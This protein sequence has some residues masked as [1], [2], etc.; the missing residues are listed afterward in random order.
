MSTDSMSKPMSQPMSEASNK[1]LS[2]EDAEAAYLL[3]EFIAQ[4]AIKSVTKAFATL[5][6]VIVTPGAPLQVPP[7]TAHDY[8]IAGVIGMTQEK[9][10]GTLFLAF[11]KKTVF[12]I[13]G[14]FYKR[15]F[16]KIDPSVHQGVGEITNVIYS[17]LKDQLNTRGHNFKMALPGVIIG[18]HRY[19]MLGNTRSLLIPFDVNGDHFTLEICIQGK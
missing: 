12:S 14:K 13:F 19:V 5:F 18:N 8:E 11:Q 10:E 16:T 3:D 1:P 6:G 17:M 15:E 9:V 4:C 2:K 7:G